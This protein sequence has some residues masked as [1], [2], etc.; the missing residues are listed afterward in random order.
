MHMQAYILC[1]H[2]N[3]FMMMHVHVLHV[4]IYVLIHGQIFFSLGREA[5]LNPQPILVVEAAR[6]W[7]VTV[8]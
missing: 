5:R 7:N 3:A 6:S 8:T 1:M 4:F 2:V